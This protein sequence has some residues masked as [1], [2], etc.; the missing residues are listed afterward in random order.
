MGSMKTAAIVVV[1]LMVGG[2]VQVVS[3]G[4]EPSPFT[5]QIN[6]IVAV[7]NSLNS[8]HDQSN[9][10]LAILPND[11]LPSHNINKA[12]NRLGAME[13]KLYLLDNLVNIIG[14]EV[15]GIPA[16]NKH[17]P[18]DVVT[19]LDEVASSAGGIAERVTQ[20][21]GLPPDDIHPDFLG[22]LGLVRE[23]ALDVN[24]TAMFYSG[25][26][27]GAPPFVCSDFTNE[28]NCL[29]NNCLWVSGVCL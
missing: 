26:I 20:F 5:P 12:V 1:F 2:S 3:A 21:L 27:G 29:L 16:D 22:A 9:R 25:E 7:V 24:E 11:I 18:T 23:A 28:E 10:I 14:E 6:Q 15:M 13:N 8:I 19:A 4:V 17:E